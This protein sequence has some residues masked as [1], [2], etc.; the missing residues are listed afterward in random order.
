MNATIE[1]KYNIEKDFYYF[2]VKDNDTNTIVAFPYA[3]QKKDVADI[4]ETLLKITFRN[5]KTRA[6]FYPTEIAFQT[7]AILRFLG[8]TEN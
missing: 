4:V 8:I 1:R 7:K 6:S 3:Y 2:S 5:I